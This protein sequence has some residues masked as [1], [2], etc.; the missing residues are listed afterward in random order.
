M[1]DTRASTEQASEICAAARSVT[2]GA[3]KPALAERPLLTPGQAGEV[4]GLFKVLANDSR[5]RLLHALERAGE[6]CVSDLAAQVGMQP[7]AV[8][9]QLQRLLDRRILAA[10][11]QGTN[12]F[13]RI[14]DPCVPSLL[15]LGMCLIEETRQ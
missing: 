11:R 8:S 9:N 12:V 7:Q 10:R 3:G 6:L 5:L 13:Y 4:A 14:A 15:D 1:T 2:A